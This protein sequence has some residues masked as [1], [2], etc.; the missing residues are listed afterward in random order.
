MFNKYH[1]LCKNNIRLQKMMG[2]F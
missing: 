2:L 1:F